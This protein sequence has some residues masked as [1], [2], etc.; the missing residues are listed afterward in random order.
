MDVRAFH[1][2]DANPPRW[3]PMPRPTHH[4]P[5]PGI[6]NTSATGNRFLRESTTSQDP[7]S[8]YSTTVFLA[9]GVQDPAA[10]LRLLILLAGDIESNP[11]PATQSRSCN[12]CK[13]VIRK[14][15]ANRPTSS[16]PLQCK[17][18]D[19]DNVCHRIK[20]CSGISRYSSK[21][22][23]LCKLHNPATQSTAHHH[24]S[25]SDPAVS[26]TT[27]PATTALPPLPSTPQKQQCYRCKKTIRRG[28]IPILCGQCKKPFHAKCT[29]LTREAAAQAKANPG[30]WT[31]KRCVTLAAPDPA[32]IDPSSHRSVS[33]SLRK[34]YKPSLKIYQWNADGL[35]TKIYE[36][37][38][39]L[40][41]HDI[42]IC[43]IQ[44]T[45]L[46]LGDSTPRIPGYACLRDDRKA[47]YGGG[48]IT[49]IKETLV[50]ERI[51]Y[52]TRWATEVMTFRTKLGRNKWLQLSNVYV[53]P[54]T[55]CHT[56]VK[57][58]STIIPTSE[59]CIIVGDFNAHS[60]VWDH[61]F[62]PDN[63]GEEIEE[64]LINEDLETLNTGVNTRISRIDNQRD[65][66]PDLTICGKTFS[67][68]C[69][70]E[71]AECIGSSDHI[72]ICVKISTSVNHQSIR[73]SEA[74]W[75]IK[76]VDWNAFSV[77]AEQSICSISPDA[78]IKTRIALFN[79]ALIS[80]ATENVGRVKRPKKPKPWMNPSVRTAVR[81]RNRLWRERTKYA[82]KKSWRE[83]WLTAC[84][85]ASETA[86]EAKAES[87]KD[88]LEEVVTEK[89]SDELWKVIKSLDGCPDSNSPNEVLIHKKRRIT[90][91]RRKADVFMQHYASV[92]KLKFTKEDRIINRELKKRLSNEDAQPPTPF[93]MR[94]LKRAISKMKTKGAAGPDDI[95]P[96]FL[97]ALG[98]KS[99]QVLLDIFNSSFHLADCP[100]VWKNALIIPLL[101]SGKPAGELKS[102]R[103]ISLTS[104]VVKLFERML[105]DRIT[106]LAETNGWLSSYQAGFRRGRS[107][108]DQILRMVQAIED[109]FQK[110]KMERSVLVLLD[111]SAAFDTVW[112]QKLLLTMLNTGV[113]HAYVKWLFHFLNNRQARVKFNGAIS[114]SRKLHQGLPQGSVLSPL[115]FIFYI[116]SLA[117]QLPSS[118]TNCLFADDVSILATHR[119]LQSALDEIQ[120]AVD[121][122]AEWCKSWK[123]NLNASKS[124]V[125][126]FSTYGKDASWRPDLSIDGASVKFNPNP[127][128]LGVTLDRSL[129]FAP[130]TTNVAE[131]V[132][133]KT[134]VLAALSHSD[135]GCSRDQLKA[136]YL[137][138]IRSIMDYG[139]AGWQPWLKPSNV[140]IL[141]RSQ[142]KALGR[143]TGQHVG[144][145]FGSKNL[146][147]GIP[148]YETTIKRNCLK[149]QEKGLR[150]P[151]DHPKNIA[152]T[153]NVPPRTSRQS[154]RSLA[155]KLTQ[156][157][158]INITNRKPITLFPNTPPWEDV[159]DISIYDT[160]PGVAK[161]TDEL[162]SKREAT[163]RR[164]NELAADCNYV[165][166]TDGSAS[167]GRL[168]GGAAAV[169]TIGSA[170]DPRV[171][172]T[173]HKRGGSLTCSYE[174]EAT[175]L[176]LAANWMLEHCAKESRVL[177]C[178]DSKS[179]CQKLIGN[180]IFIA[181]LRQLL[182]SVPGTIIIQWVPGHSDIPGNELADAAAKAATTI[183]AVPR[184]ISF[185]SA[186][187]FINLK[188]ADKP[189]P[190]PRP[191]EAYKGKTKKQEDRITNRADQV[192]LAC[193][194]S[195]KHK[196]FRKYQHAL[197][198]YTDPSCPRCEEPL[199]TLEHWL[200][201]CP[202]TREAVYRTYRFTPTTLEVMSTH[203]RETVSLARAKLLA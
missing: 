150:L 6:T 7:C 46:R 55:H 170:Y 134:N 63:R 89:S 177:I 174:E 189:F 30:A 125:S 115:L 180:S 98:D 116:N 25:P 131:R 186:S 80:S 1:S 160:V 190:H 10:V 78:S 56:E 163:I 83:D 182:S 203:T 108:E 81:K 18:V 20:T 95:P 84:H 42:D 127:V 123:L 88:F 106:H 12:S 105:A 139:G 165:I 143:V 140:A 172:R 154:C 147:A 38:H 109:G 97:K 5:T 57:L 162:A 14:P 48:L 8:V 199:H 130:H 198:G 22:R 16:Q 118:N 157:L 183:Q 158:P 65:S 77:A 41:K 52:G 79:G 200:L 21:P 196:A 137:S 129:S 37:K 121:I 181:D 103:P 161:R 155:K 47:M 132:S 126:F 75:R 119:K 164:I 135:W 60:P 72:P 71:L 99:L 61:H 201:Y 9:T 156:Q 54:P 152:F 188:V 187:S 13:K 31:C 104:C 36:L 185:S 40:L 68:K 133:G 32:L 176:E 43:M 62:P 74:K 58:A 146:E 195:G 138:S 93:S 193:L 192:L 24:P 23:W 166:Y 122:V 26:P 167:Q 50:Y 28:F 110:P 141:E 2:N 29:K 168:D 111:F 51:G 184:S 159:S 120:T 90:S 197:D 87:W 19:C 64:W 69:T 171:I 15:P 149:A 59:D 49:Y 112:R 113:P 169:I 136:V 11:G 66:A 144:S 151:D 194:R 145:P 114:N 100:Q 33:E 35:S 107:C 178:T 102:F 76:N 91:N 117:A 101:K 3:S 148:T 128:L 124:E 142:N 94:E 86:K 53:P 173:L 179:I 92:S 27:P 73:G 96:S 45:K 39:R 202:G 44:E 67:R 191:N 17:Q 175:A 153:N 70:W 34:Q 85:E 4:L 82:D